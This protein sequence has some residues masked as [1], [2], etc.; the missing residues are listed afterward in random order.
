MT[1]HD[2]TW[3]D[4]TW[5]DMTWPYI[6]LHDCC[7]CVYTVHISTVNYWYLLYTLVQW[8]ILLLTV[9]FR[10]D[11]LVQRLQLW[12]I[13]PRSACTVATRSTLATLQVGTSSYAHMHHASN[14][15][16]WPVSQSTVWSSYKLYTYN[17]CV[18]QLSSIAACYIATSEQTLTINIFY[19]CIL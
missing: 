4:V 5:R 19:I 6:I 14:D 15:C 12:S 11:T 10:W 18:Q 9:H 3:R 13:L 7:I 8:T 16:T 17:V 1:W 2:V